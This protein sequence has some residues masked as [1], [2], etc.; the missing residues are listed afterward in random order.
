MTFNLL[1]SDDLKYEL[2]LSYLGEIILDKKLPLEPESDKSTIDATI[3][4]AYRGN[5]IDS[6]LDMI[7]KDELVYTAWPIIQ[8]EAVEVE[9]V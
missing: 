1:I 6:M 5:K 9:S 8:K 3:V 7:D 2:K 4:N